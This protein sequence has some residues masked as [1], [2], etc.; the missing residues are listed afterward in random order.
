MKSSFQLKTCEVVHCLQWNLISICGLCA[1][2]Y[3]CRCECVRVCSCI[4]V[5]DAPGHSSPASV[6]QSFAAL[7][8]A[9][10]VSLTTRTLKLEG[11]PV[12]EG[13]GSSQTAAFFATLDAPPRILIPIQF[14][15][16][17]KH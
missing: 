9:L 14:K 5:M 16:S 4:Y 8:I 7:L 1:R 2:V 11:T 6:Q 13:G 12:P 3:V 10:L 15:I 17:V